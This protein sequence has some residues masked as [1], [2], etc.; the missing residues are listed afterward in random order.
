MDLNKNQILFLVEIAKQ[1]GKTSVS[2]IGRNVWNTAVSIY[3]NMSILRDYG[4]ISLHGKKNTIIPELTK[5]GIL[6]VNVYFNVAK[7]LNTLQN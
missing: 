7:G 1:D 6:E 3:N 5:K 2:D 4:Y